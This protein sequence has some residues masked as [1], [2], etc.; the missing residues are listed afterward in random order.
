M[1]PPMNADKRRLDGITEGVIGSASYGDQQS[2]AEQTRTDLLEP[3]IDADKRRLDGITERV[4]GCAYTVSNTLGAGFL[5]KVYENA[6]SHEVC[7]AGLKTELQKRL[8]VMYDGVLVGDYVADML[9][10][11][12]VLV[13]IKTVKALDN[14]HVAQCMNYLK[15]TDLR[16]CLL[17]NFGCP[18]VDVRRVVNNF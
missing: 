1:E 15:A 18:R 8:I 9:V 17:I 12:L 7:K 10:E 3:Q 14:V 6:L 2:H 5:E 16:V 11:E 13:E 4:I